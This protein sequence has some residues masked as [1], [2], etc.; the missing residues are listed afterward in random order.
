M[1]VEV[2][3]P[4]PGAAPVKLV[5][6]VPGTVLN[7]AQTSKAFGVPLKTVRADATA[8]KLR[9]T[10]ER[11]GWAIPVAA[12]V[13]LYL[14]EVISDAAEVCNQIAKSTRTPKR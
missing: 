13:S 14:G 8:G 4:L 12:A 1:K 3:L 5:L 6:D 9:A 7:C 2:A 11:G 10:Y